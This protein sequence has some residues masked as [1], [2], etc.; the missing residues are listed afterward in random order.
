MPWPMWNREVCAFVTG[1]FDRKNKACITV[2][3]SLDEGQVWF[4]EETP[5]CAEHHV[6]VIIKRGYHYF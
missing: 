3:K 2:L 4:G 6:R 5:A 1:M